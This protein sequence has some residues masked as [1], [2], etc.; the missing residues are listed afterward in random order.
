MKK[1]LLSLLAVAIAM[2]AQAE[3]HYQFWI[4][5]TE[6][7]SDNFQN[8]QDESIKSGTAKY[9]ANNNKLILTNVTIQPNSGTRAIRN[10]NCTDLTIEFRGTC[11]LKTKNADAIRAESGGE[12]HGNLKL[13]ATSGSVVT[14]ETEGTHAIST[15][16]SIDISGPG[17]YNITSN[18]NDQTILCK[19]WL[20]SSGSI[21][22][23]YD[24]GELNFRDDCNVTITNTGNGNC[25]KGDNFS[26]L[27]FGKGTVVFDNS[28]NKPCIENI[29]DGDD[30]ETSIRFL[31]HTTVLDPLGA[32]P[33]D[34]SIVLNGEK[35][36]G[37][38]LISNDYVAIINENY[39][40]SSAFRVA[41][42]ELFPK[43]YI[44]S[45]DVEGLTTLDLSSRNLGNVTGINYLSN[46]RTLILTNNNLPSLSIDLPLLETLYCDQNRI[47]WMELQ[48]L[49]ALKK[50]DCH[51]N[52]LTWM[53][54]ST[55]SALTY[56]N[57]AENSSMTEFTSG[58]NNTALERLFLTNNSSLTTLGV[59]SLTGLKQLGCAFCTSLTTLTAILLPNLT[60]ID[61]AGCSSMTQLWCSGSGVTSLNV[62]NCT[63]LTNI[64]ANSCKFTT[65]TITGL[66]NLTDLDVSNNTLLKTLNCS[67][68]ALTNLNLDY[69]TALE[70]LDCSNNAFV[71]LGLT[72][73]TA[74][75]SANLSFNNFQTVYVTGLSNLSTLLL[76]D[77]P[78]LKYLTCYDNALNML[79]VARCPLLESINCRNNCFTDLYFTDLSKLFNLNVSNNPYLKTLNCSNSAVRGFNIEHCDALESIN[80]SN[81]PGPAELEL[82]HFQNLR[83]LNLLNATNLTRLA[84][85]DAPQLT[86]LN[87][88]GCTGMQILSVKYTALPQLT[89]NNLSE[90][91]DFYCEQNNAMTQLECNNN[92]KLHYM[93][94]IYNSSLATLNCTYNTALTE[95]RCY[96]NALSTLQVTGCTSLQTLTATQ[97]AF[98][99]LTIQN[100][101][102]L[103]TLNLSNTTS[104]T[105][106]NCSSNAQLSSFNIDGCTALE[107]VYCQN[108]AFTELNLSN[109]PALK[110]IDASN[111]NLT[112][113]NAAGSTALQHLIVQNNP[114]LSKYD[115]TFET[116]EL[117][118][119]NISKTKGLSFDYMGGMPKL[120]ALYMDETSTSYNIDIHNN[121]CL[122][123]LS[124]KNCPQLVNLYCD[125]NA[126]VNL[127]VSGNTQMQSFSCSNNSLTS[128]RLQNCP[129]L[130]FVACYQNQL[131]NSAMT[132]LVGDL[133]TIPTSENPGQLRVMANNNEGNVFTSAHLDAATAKR[134]NALMN[135]GS[136]VSPSALL[137]DINRD[138]KVDV[139]D[140][141]IIINIMLGR[142]QA[143][144]YPGNADLTGDGVID[145]SDVNKIVNIMLGKEP[146][147]S[148]P[149][150]QPVEVTY[151]YTSVAGI[152][153]AGFTESDLPHDGF[154]TAIEDKVLSDQYATMDYFHIYFMP[155]NS[156]YL[157]GLCTAS[158]SSGFE[159][160]SSMG[161]VVW[162]AKSGKKITKVI[163]QTLNNS[164]TNRLEI[165]SNDT[166]ATITKE[167]VLTTC[168]F[169]GN[170]VNSFTLS[171]N[172]TTNPLLIKKITV[173]Y[174]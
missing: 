85:N 135:D 150:P 120:Q 7:T 140:V 33:D 22:I 39:F 99:N 46:L 91:Y 133:P 23:G 95:L 113:L 157:L 141:N 101:P 20:P 112:S 67:G 160:D 119:L 58:E 45:T 102:A 76:T 60:S 4:G 147:G 52:A 9:D 149:T 8:I 40:P 116:G 78:N 66:P 169:S 123:T 163:V 2:A 68:N 83:S 1:I 36:K 159:W 79:N 35:V 158:E 153:A 70:S 44:N 43:G 146:G 115:I 81:N 11:K 98:V 27:Y 30:G 37:H 131:S 89:A 110:L 51:D 54:V 174:Q 145:V 93:E 14:I 164:G 34:K 69:L 31:S 48:F 64:H 142:A 104:L 161:K 61:A 28:A 114:L 136:P 62:A 111:N 92:P 49:P 13:V 59:S 96:I 73:C 19:G 26:S 32:E 65:L 129:A 109:M 41:L 171:R 75:Q 108:C 56:V 6:V 3:A 82:I 130:R 103:A 117:L 5:S 122:T 90:L 29:N 144:S 84:I 94:A 148:E 165:T 18:Y 24:T 151:D 12:V 87:I 143:S 42:R 154:I 125:N 132:T 80:L 155:Y 128:L 107:N 15:Q 139:S 57:A 53:D 105:T 121:P 134:W 74:L 21:Y 137:G 25:I 118:E 88:S 97:N 173:T 10:Q 17:T 100:M 86:S 166:G 156:I 168:T 72:A 162:N 50:L 71:S 106:L 170:G 55:N 152:Q 127:D 124:M 126:L 167:G 47:Q 38:M 16:T 77:C 172:I 138:G 63:A